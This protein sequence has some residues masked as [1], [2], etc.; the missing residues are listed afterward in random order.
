MGKSLN[1][2]DFMAIP[3]LNKSLVLE[4]ARCEWIDKRENV[5]ALRPS[6]A[7]NNTPINL[8][9]QTVTQS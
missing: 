2:F 4:L 5:I 8:T 1:T 6:G 9:R 3:T 7:G